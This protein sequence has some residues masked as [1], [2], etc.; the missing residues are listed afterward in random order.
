MLRAILPAVCFAPGASS[1]QQN[2]AINRARQRIYTAVIGGGWKG[3]DE[4]LKLSIAVDAK[5]RQFLTLPYGAESIVGVRGVDG[6]GSYTI[7][8]EWFEFTQSDA[9]EANGRS[10]L[11]DLGAGF[12]TFLAIPSGGLCPVFT[13]IGT[14]SITLVGFTTAGALVSETLTFGGAGQQQAQNTY[15]QIISVEIAAGANAPT[16]SNAIQWVTPAP[17]RFTDYSMFPGGTA[18]VSG[19]YFADDNVN[20]WVFRAGQTPV[21]WR[22]LPLMSA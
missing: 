12:N 17:T 3:G 19:V 20:L 21:Q 9:I 7:Q 16:P 14:A 18:P 11:E 8:N 5:G 4:T 10:V 1:S 6:N 15:S 22:Q 13:T 2:A